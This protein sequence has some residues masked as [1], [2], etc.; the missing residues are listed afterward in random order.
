ME[1]YLTKTKLNDAADLA[2]MCGLGSVASAPV[3]VPAPAPAPAP[4]TGASTTGRFVIAESTLMPTKQ[5]RM[6]PRSPLL[7]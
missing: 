1:G 6:R 5:V 7:Y 2:E 4:A 3:T